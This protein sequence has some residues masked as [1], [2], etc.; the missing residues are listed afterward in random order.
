MTLGG[1]EAGRC[2]G[3]GSS[4]SL[5]HVLDFL[6]QA[7]NNNNNSTQRS[8]LEQLENALCTHYAVADVRSLGLGSFQHLVTKAAKIQQNKEAKVLYQGSLCCASR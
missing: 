5:H 1:N 6:C 8:K 7:N 2:H 4:A 3:G